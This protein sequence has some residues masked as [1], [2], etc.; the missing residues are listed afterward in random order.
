MGPF[1][2]LLMLCAW[3]RFQPVDGYSRGAPNAACSDM[4]PLVSL[5]ESLCSNFLN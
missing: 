3:F 2:L 4:E 5:L 1:P